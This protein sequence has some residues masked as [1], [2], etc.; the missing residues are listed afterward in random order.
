MMYGEAVVFFNKDLCSD[1]KYRRKQ[2]MQ[3]A[4]KMRY[5]AAQF[6]A[7]LKDDLWKTNARHA[8]LMAQK[9]YAAVKDIPGVQVTRKV[10]S[11][12]VFATVPPEIIPKLQDQFFFYVWDEVSSEVRWMCSFD[13]REE[14]IETFASL[15]KKLR[16]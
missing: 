9:L 2:G 14:D 8:N 1:F 10:E 4:S 16:D 15:L 13:T 7:Y 12:A 3:L 5:I 6:N 11:N